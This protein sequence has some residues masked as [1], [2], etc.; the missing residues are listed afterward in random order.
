[1]QNAQMKVQ[2]GQFGVVRSFAT[3]IELFRQNEFA[4]DVYL[5]Q[6]GVIK[7]SWMDSSGHETIIGLCWPGSFLGSAARFT[8]NPHPATAASITPCVV[9]RIRGD[10]F[11]HLVQ[12]DPDFSSMVHL[13]HSRD[14]LELVASL[15][16]LA[17]ISARLR[18]EGF[19]K[20]LNESVELEA[21]SK[22]GRLLLPLKRKDLAAVIKITPEHLS[23]LL[24]QLQREGILE[25]RDQWIIV[26]NRRALRESA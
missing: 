22:D 2:R 21:F 7:L 19:L 11:A 16:E 20:R 14:V 13:S 18:L 24:S 17:C 10:I 4:D 9:E 6:R 3:G 26:R 15:G 8:A 5:L 23:R 25:L 12:S 1:M